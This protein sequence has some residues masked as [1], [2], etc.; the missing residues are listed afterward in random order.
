MSHVL[1]IVYLLVKVKDIVIEREGELYTHH[2][3]ASVEYAGC[4]TKDT[5]FHLRKEAHRKGNNS[6]TK[7]KDFDKIFFYEYSS[8]DCWRYESELITQYLDYLYYS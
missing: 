8:S 7:K 4:A 2:D 3:Y 5:N 1:S 6:G